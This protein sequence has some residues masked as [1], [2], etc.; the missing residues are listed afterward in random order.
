MFD[1][2][3]KFFIE[4]YKINYALLLLVFA[5]GTYTYTKI[6]KEV[7]PTIEPSSIRIHG[8]Y[9]GASVDMLNKMADD[10]RILKIEDVVPALLSTCRLLSS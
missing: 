3:I 8:S 5:I 1:K 7:S 6:P 10:L 9:G 2:T 4:N